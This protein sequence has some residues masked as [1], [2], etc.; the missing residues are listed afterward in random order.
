MATLWAF[1]LAYA[2]GCAYFNTFYHAKQFYG[3]AEKAR[4]SERGQPGTP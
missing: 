3:Q 2:S 4:A 1:L